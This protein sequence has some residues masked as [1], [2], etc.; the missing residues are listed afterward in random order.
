MPEGVC[1]LNGVCGL[2]CFGDADAL[3]TMIGATPPPHLR[4][5]S[6]PPSTE[7]GRLPIVLVFFVPTNPSNF[8][9]ES[10]KKSGD[11]GVVVGRV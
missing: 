2:Y 1:G 10:G 9:G 3:G 6:R 8:R 7:S 4:P 5:L 11:G